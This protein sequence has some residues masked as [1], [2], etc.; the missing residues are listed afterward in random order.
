MH[1]NPEHLQ[2]TVGLPVLAPHDTVR[3]GDTN[4]ELELENFICPNASTMVFAAQRRLTGLQ[5]DTLYLCVW[6]PVVKVCAGEH[7]CHI[8]GNLRRKAEWIEELM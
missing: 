7:P 4:F 2:C 5:M 1:K 8:P 6:P 3:V